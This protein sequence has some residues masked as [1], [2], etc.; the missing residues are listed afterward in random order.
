MCVIERNCK[1]LRENVLRTWP[2]TTFDRGVVDFASPNVQ[3]LWETEQ[4]NIRFFTE[5]GQTESKKRSS[6]VET[7]GTAISFGFKKKLLPSHKK[8][9]EQTKLR[10]KDAENNDRAD[11]LDSVTN[12][13]AFDD[14]N[15]N[16]GKWCARS[17]RRSVNKILSK[18]IPVEPSDV[19]STPR[20]TPGSQRG[21]RFGIR[22]SNVVRPASTG[23]TSDRVIAHDYNVNSN[24]N[25]YKSI[26]MCAPRIWYTRLF[27]AHLHSPIAVKP[28]SK[29][30]CSPH[31]FAA[32]TASG[33]TQQY[34]QRQA[35]IHQ[36]QLQPK[37]PSPKIDNRSIVATAVNTSQQRRV[38][39]QQNNYTEN[40]PPSGKRNYAVVRTELHTNEM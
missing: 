29:S 15:G 18:W 14:N 37:Q 38:F 33:A 30:A 9:A 4:L 26:G 7:K 34:R 24:G 21:G 6:H 3:W 32:T 19:K 5:Q 1:L 40:K 28:R 10:A 20:S 27:I 39:F 2:P 17:T 22:K 12:E 36:I 16:C 13:L 25:G 8:N 31:R 35:T 23:I 11:A